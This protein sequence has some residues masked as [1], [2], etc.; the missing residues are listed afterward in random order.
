MQASQGHPKELAGTSDPAAKDVGGGA[1]EPPPR[2]Y[3]LYVPSSSLAIASG[4]A[5]TP[6]KHKD[7]EKDIHIL[8]LFSSAVFSTCFCFFFLLPHLKKILL[9][10]K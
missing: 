4:R 3:H 2:H 1:V 9:T 10:M 7:L 5:G 6:P 8:F